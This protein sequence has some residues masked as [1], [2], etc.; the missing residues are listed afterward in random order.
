[1]SS[2]VAPDHTP[3]FNLDY[4]PYLFKERDTI[5]IENITRLREDRERDES[6]DETTILTVEYCNKT[7]YVP[8]CRDSVGQVE[9]QLIC[10]HRYG[11]SGEQ[12]LCAIGHGALCIWRT[13]STRQ[14][15]A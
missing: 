3:L 13:P 7:N 6:T 4:C 12:A 1:M 9:A 15:V 2:H 8:V 11:G 5:D 14:L 10:T